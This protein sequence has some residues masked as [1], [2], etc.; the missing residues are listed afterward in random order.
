M[1]R[2]LLWIFASAGG[3]MRDKIL[4]I[5]D[6]SAFSD[7]IKSW[8]QPEAIE[9]DVASTGSEAMRKFK[10]SSGSYSVCIL[11]YNLPDMTGTDVAQLIFRQNPNQ[12]IMFMT[13]DDRKETFRNMTSHGYTKNFLM[14]DDDPRLLVN[15]IKE[16]ISQYNRIGRKFT[17]P[18]ES[19]SK[20]EKDL[21]SI[22]LR[23]KEHK[24]PIPEPSIYPQLSPTIEFPIL[25]ETLAASAYDQ[26]LQK[27]T[28]TILDFLLS[29]GLCKE[30]K[31]K[32]VVGP[33]S[34]HLEASSPWV[35]VHHANWR[36]QALQ[37]LPQEENGKL[38]YTAPLT[39][40]AEDALKIRE[41]I[42]QFLEKV[43]KVID[44]SP[45]EEVRCL[46]I[47]WFKF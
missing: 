17:G 32:I 34:T 27:Q 39:V 25:I 7:S 37:H 36:Q 33:S 1:A 13:A 4:L 22:G 40:S 15:R 18:A 5:E 10:A 24:S 9:V 41:M 44:P 45:S 6:D 38:H 35:R 19:A 47:D 28:K 8:L 2:T 26:K 46:N 11:D 30:E 29:T 43:D 23:S 14:K 31:G 3:C 21:K 12:E 42:V 16:T 20:I